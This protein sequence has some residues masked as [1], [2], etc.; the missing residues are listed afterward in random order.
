MKS[1]E[2]ISYFQK[3]QIF[4]KEHSHKDDQKMRQQ[5]INDI[6]S[7]HTILIKQCMEVLN[8]S[9]QT[10][11]I[12]LEYNDVTGKLSAWMIE[13]NQ[14]LESSDCQPGDVTATKASLENCKVSHFRTV[15]NK[16]LYDM[17]LPQT[18]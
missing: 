11:P 13:V 8:L 17:V 4:I 16:I 7:C 18:R 15:N 6:V 10:L 2:K 5:Q 9:R 14:Q 12:W 1:N 3:H